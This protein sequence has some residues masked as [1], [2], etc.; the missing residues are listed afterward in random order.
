MKTLFIFRKQR[1]FCAK[2][3]ITDKAGFLNRYLK[4]HNLRACVVAVSG[5]VDSAVVLGIVARAARIKG[6]PIKKILAVML[7]VFDVKSAT[8][9]KQAFLRGKMVAKKFNIKLSV[10]DLT[11]SFTK[12]KNKIDYSIKIN[13]KGWASGQL[14]SYL[15]TPAL[16]YATS[17]LMQDGFPAVLCGTTNRDEGAYLGYV[18]KASDGMVDIQ[19]I[20]DLHKSEV[21][22][23]GIELGVP[24][25]IMS[26]APSGDMFDDR[27]DEE[28]F[29]APYDF[30]ELYLSVKSHR[31][32]KKISEIKKR[33]SYSAKRQ[34]KN[35]G[36]RLE[37]LHK[38]N[39]HKYLVGSPAVHLDIYESAVPG[40][41]P[42]MQFKKQNYG[43]AKRKNKKI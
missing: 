42:G 17:L 10:V 12:I 34:F 23:T 20:S 11:E 29:G 6:S 36:A 15:R 41:W 24:D 40:G 33:W 25:K 35:L 32:R 13:G 31:N 1:S 18:G 43:T 14:V 5:G 8:N 21:Y 22:K 9:Q 2:K 27:K 7:P 30:V 3:Y 4:K 37:R 39:S 38:Y 28:V 19:I 16:Y 26:V